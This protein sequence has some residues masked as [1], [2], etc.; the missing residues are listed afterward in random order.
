[1]G[2]PDRRSADRHHQRPRGRAIS[3]QRRF[4]RRHE[5]PKHDTDRDVRTVLFGLDRV[6]SEGRRDG[7]YCQRE[8][9]ADRWQN[10]AREPPKEEERD[11]RG[12]DRQG[13][14]RILAG[15]EQVNDDSLTQHESGWRDLTVSE[16]FE[17]PGEIRPD[18]AERK[19]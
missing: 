6:K 13:A 16:R 7:E 12:N 9:G 17:K 1:V 3:V 18:D 11:D 4:Q 5:P 2:R 8:H 10:R 19:E 14:E 15:A